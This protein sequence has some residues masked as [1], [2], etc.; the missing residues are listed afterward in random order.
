VRAGRSRP[1][2]WAHALEDADEDAEAEAG[3]ELVGDVDQAGGC[4]GVLL[5]GVRDAEAV[6]G[7]RGALADAVE[8]MGSAIR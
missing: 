1:A 6:S 7:R 2:C 8:I 4:A 3:A 5:A